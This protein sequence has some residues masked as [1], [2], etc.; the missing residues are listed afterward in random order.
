LVA[1]AADVGPV[2]LVLEMDL[3]ETSE[4]MGWRQSSEHRDC[5]FLAALRL[6]SK[7]RNGLGRNSRSDC[8][9]SVFAVSLVIDCALIAGLLLAE[10]TPVGYSLQ[11]QQGGT[12]ESDLI[13]LATAA[14][15]SLFACRKT[16]PTAVRTS[17]GGIEVVRI[18][19]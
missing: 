15:L 5:A 14:L 3:S 11:F 19:Q 9:D 4:G 6:S 12:E 18:G 8:R 1:K 10:A 7:I 2:A 17:F 16:Y 13:E